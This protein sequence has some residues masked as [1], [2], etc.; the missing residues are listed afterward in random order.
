MYFESIYLDWDGVLSDFHLEAVRAH[1]RVGKRF[2]S[3]NHHGTPLQL[4]GED[5]RRVWP[6]GMPCHTFCCGISPDTD[7]WSDEMN[8]VFWPPI[9][10]DPFFWSNMDPFPWTHDLIHLLENHCDHLVY[11][12][13]PDHTST[14]YAGKFEWKCRQRLPR[15]ELFM[16]HD[17]WRLAHPGSLLIDDGAHH[18]SNWMLRCKNK[19]QAQG[20]AILFPQPWNSNYGFSRDPLEFVRK[21]LASSPTTTPATFGIPNAPAI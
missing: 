9:R 20:N 10:Q 11:V 5:L 16:C 12:T 21:F 8:E 18:I 1:M 13:S 7:Y 15:H 17:K 14:S 6:R 3:I 2:P 4:Q 19:F